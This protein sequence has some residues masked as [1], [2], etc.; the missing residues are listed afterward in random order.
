MVPSSTSEREQKWKSSKQI[1]DDCNHFAAI[2]NKIINEPELT[3][4]EWYSVVQYHSSTFRCGAVKQNKETNKQTKNMLVVTPSICN[5]KKNDK[6]N[7][8]ISVSKFNKSS[9][10]MSVHEVSDKVQLAPRGNND[11]C[12]FTEVMTCQTGLI[13]WTEWLK[14]AK[15]GQLECHNYCRSSIQFPCINFSLI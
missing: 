6:L 3:S 15:C 12:L 4:L 14:L 13:Y 9:I 8:T 11:S 5:L 2:I 7:F 10:V 1:T